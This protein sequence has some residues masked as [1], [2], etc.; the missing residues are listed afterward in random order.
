[1]ANVVREAKYIK[2]DVKNNNNKYWYIRQFDDNSVV[3]EYGRV[4]SSPQVD[5]KNFTAESVATQFV[6]KKC[7]EKEG[8]SKGYTK[9]KVISGNPQTTTSNST[10]LLDIALKQIEN[11]SIEAADLIRYLTKANVHNIISATTMTYDE[12]KGCF[13]TPCGIVTQEGIDEARALLDDLL[14]YIEKKDY[15]NPDFITKLQSYIQLI[16]RKVGRKLIAQD[17]FPDV[18]AFGKENQILDSLDAS[19]QQVL[20]ASDEESNDKEVEVP[21]LFKTKLELVTDQS[22]IDRI[23]KFYNSTKQ[24]IHTSS[25]LKVKR[26]FSV[27]IADMSE[28]YAKDGANVGGVMELWHGTRVSNVLSILKSGLVIP[29][30]NA[31]HVCGRMFGDGA[32]FSD[33]STKSLNYAQGY[34]NGTRDNNCFM[35]VA[36]VAMGKYFVPSSPSSNFPKPGYDSTFAK[37][38]QSG[39]MNNEMIVYRLGQCNLKYLVEFS[40]K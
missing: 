20:T 19:L 25:I 33:Q 11:S 38:G 4:G 13:S 23:I 8:A 36:D 5:T 39:V 1:M 35:F 2:S 17:I 29:K 27:E 32:Y 18:D 7:R 40:D 6:D 31:P 24:S 37:G 34:W 22:V 15:E 28:G 16:P 26:V 30:S 12:S 10:N 3:V 9:L 21:Q 14:P